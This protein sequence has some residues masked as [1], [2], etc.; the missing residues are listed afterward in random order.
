MIDVVLPCRNAPEA[1]MLTLQ[2]FWANAYDP[3]I[4]ASV[5]MVDNC[6]TDA[7]VGEVLRHAAARYPE[8]H[9]VVLNERNVGVWC[10]VN[11]GL[12]MGRSE[13]A[14][15]LTSD[16]L[17]GHGSLAKIR[18]ELAADRTLGILGPEV[19]TGL[20][21]C[22]ALAMQ[23]RV[24]GLD[25]PA[26]MEVDRS[27]Y[28]G[29]AWMLRRELLSKIGWYDPRMYVAFGDT[30][31][32]ERMRLANV[33]YGVLRGVPC[34]HLDKQSRRADGTA[35]QDSEM[36]LKDAREF[37]QKWAEHPDVVR[38]HTPGLIENMTAW[39]EMDMGGWAAA[40]VR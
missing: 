35:G 25:R 3:D 17:L 12:T 31:F 16:V 2:F 37:A 26:A 18:G 1:L 5:T 32:M 10:S 14:F 15:V 23:P 27:T 20:G 11:R 22:P 30:D 40:R 8:T 21:A 39:K 28:N 19:F 36:E 9:R 38:R 6:S 7:R 13:Y 4:V 34:V 33:G 29:A 24:L